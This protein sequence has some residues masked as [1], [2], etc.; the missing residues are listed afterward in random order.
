M[1]YKAMLKKA[2]T[3]P[4]IGEELKNRLRANLQRIERLAA[5]HKEAKSSN[6]RA[7]DDEQY[8]LALELLREDK[9]G[10]LQYGQS[11]PQEGDP[12]N[13]SH[14]L[15]EEYMCIRNMSEDPVTCKES[16]VDP[17]QLLEDADIFYY[18]AEYLMWLADGFV[19]MMRAR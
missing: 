5:L 12:W 6:N 2:Q 15:L 1:T 17:A 8:N 18:A 10:W 14:R 9:G 13:L 7:Y 16:G 4:K 11:D 19:D 3:N